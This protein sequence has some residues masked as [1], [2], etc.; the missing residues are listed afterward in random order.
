[1]TVLYEKLINID[2]Y[3]FDALRGPW[4]YESEIAI[5][6][7]SDLTTS[8]S[9]NEY[10]LFP[11]EGRVIF[12]TPK[13]VDLVIKIQDKNK[14]RM[15]VRIA[16]NSITNNIDLYGLGSMHSNI[17]SIVDYLGNISVIPEPTTTIVCSS[18]PWINCIQ[19]SLSVATVSINSVTGNECYDVANGTY[20]Y[21][22]ILDTAGITGW[23]F[24]K[25][26]RD[27]ALIILYCKEDLN[28]YAQ[29]YDR[30][31]DGSLFGAAVNE[32]TCSTFENDRF[33]NITDSGTC[34]DQVTSLLLGQFALYGVNDC[35]LF[36]ASV[37]F[38]KIGD[39]T[40]PT[41]AAILEVSPVTDTTISFGSVS[42]SASPVFIGTS[43]GT[44][45]WPLNNTNYD[46]VRLQS[47]Y[48]QSEIG[49]SRNITSLSLHISSAP[50]VDMNNWTIRMRH[51]ALAVAVGTWES[52]DWTTVY[53]LQES[54]PLFSSGWLTF[55]FQTPFLYD[56][57]TNLMIDFSFKNVANTGD[58]GLTWYASFAANRS[59]YLGSNTL[60]A[61]PITWA[62]AV[63]AG[64]LSTNVSTI[65]LESEYTTSN[66]V[67]ITFTNSGGTSIGISEP[68][69][70]DGTYFA[71]DSNFATGVIT[72]EAGE[73][74]TYGVYFIGS[75][76]AGTYTDVLTFSNDSPEGAVSYNLS[77][78]VT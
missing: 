31:G 27:V 10:N 53:R 63:P 72:L 60:G 2:G 20:V 43:A 50:S 21:S 4:D 40:T 51:T 35:A 1:M 57:I 34:C 47:I 9:E 29:I 59:L 15:G 69:F 14:I 18:S 70:A 65:E 46:H 3:I 16:N 52:T 78:V 41:E 5:Y 8:I 24:T 25:T 30:V 26:D 37:Q 39:T 32:A 66:T 49:V 74:V 58:A 76:T 7:S 13:Y 28:W 61:D 73:H 22:S 62:G 48:L 36:Q 56:G 71:L 23:W 75:D 45:A 68:S 6:E 11:R 44:W 12:S 54:D 42:K 33:R 77:E 17:S 55:V 64:T 19:P 38:S 67:T